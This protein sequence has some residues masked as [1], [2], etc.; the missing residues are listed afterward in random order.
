MTIPKIAY[1]VIRIETFVLWLSGVLMIMNALEVKLLSLTS[2]LVLIGSLI[3]SLLMDARMVRAKKEISRPQGLQMMGIYFLVGIILLF[4]PISM[5]QRT[6]LDSYNTVSLILGITL[7]LI[8][9]IL[10]VALWTV[11]HD[12]SSG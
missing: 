11:P 6:A 2:F 3:F 9:S 5:A 7:L 8:N 1:K 10:F 4:S 12:K